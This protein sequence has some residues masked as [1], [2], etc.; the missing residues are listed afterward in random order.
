MT[1]SSAR[2]V[3]P[4]FRLSVVVLVV[5]GAA[6]SSFAQV[7]NPRLVER[8][9]AQIL[10]GPGSQIGV[11][12]RDRTPVETRDAAGFW[13]R[14]FWEPNGVIIEQVRSDGPAARAGLMKGDVVTAFDGQ[15]VLSV[16]QFS[17]LVE[18]TP[19]GWMVKITIVRDGKARDIPITP[20]L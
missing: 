17:R 15:R 1:T 7:P 8:L 5:F 6:S 10:R 13:S 9:G 4:C 19:P 16:N 3:A 12:T 14:W 2:L 18:E 11:S 20:T